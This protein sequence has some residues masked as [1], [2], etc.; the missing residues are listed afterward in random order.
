MKEVVAHSLKYPP[1]ASLR[2][3]HLDIG[4]ADYWGDLELQHSV[5]DSILGAFPN[6]LCITFFVAIQWHRDPAKGTWHGLV[7]PAE[8]NTVQALLKVT[9]EE[10]IKD[11]DGILTSIPLEGLLPA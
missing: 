6:L 5:L 11:Y 8:L 1:P 9:P 4:H 7:P 10:M 2:K 3:L